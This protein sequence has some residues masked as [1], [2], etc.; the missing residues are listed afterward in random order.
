MICPQCGKSLSSRATICPS[1][2]VAITAADNETAATGSAVSYQPPSPDEQTGPPTTPYA[3]SRY[4]RPPITS[5]EPPATATINPTMTIPVLT[6]SEPPLDETP[7]DDETVWASVPPLMTSAEPEDVPFAMTPAANEPDEPVAPTEPV[8]D[9]LLGDES[10][11]AERPAIA[12]PKPPLPDYDTPDIERPAIHVIKP[13]LPDYDTPDI[14]R[15]AV[16]QALVSAPTDEQLTPIGASDDDE[17]EAE[18]VTMTN[19]AHSAA[20]VPN[21]LSSYLDAYMAQ[22]AA[23]V[24]ATAAAGNAA[25]P[26]A[27]NNNS[28]DTPGGETIERLFGVQPPPRGRTAKNAIQRLW[29]RNMPPEWAVAPWASIP[30]GALAALV[31][32]LLVTAIGLIFWSRA[33]GYLLGLGNALGANESLGQ[34][35]LSPNLLQLFLL[36]HGVPMSLTLGAP[37]VTGSFS[38]LESLPLTGL[39]LIPACALILAGYVAAASDF[40]HRLRFSVLRGALVG[41]VYGVLLLLVAVFGSGTVKLAPNTIIELHPSLGLAFL[42]GLL[43]GALLGALGGLLTI[44]RHHLFT[45]SRHPDLLA[46]ASWGALIALGSGLLLATVALAA[47]MAAHVVGAT[48]PAGPSGN[49]LLNLLGGVVIAISLLIVVAPVGA[50]WLFAL[51]TGATLDSWFSSAGVSPGSGRATFG[52]LVAQHHPASGAWWLLLLVPL[53]SYVIGGRAAAHI[54]RADSLR[55]GA[56]AGWLMGV[57]LSIMLLVLTLLSRVLIAS[58]ATIFGRQVITNLGIAPSA[59]AVFVL[60]LLVGGVV[61]ALAG[62]SALLAPDPG[63]ILAS[64]A[65]PLL[66]RIDPALALAARPGTCSMRPVVASPRTTMRVLF[67]AA[68]LLAVLLLA[69]FLVMVLIGWIAS[70]VAPISAVRGFDSFFAGIAVGVP[71]LLLASAAILA[72]T[73][74]LPPLLTAQHTPAPI[75]PRYPTAQ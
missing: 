12:A 75:I 11:D 34:A 66:P 67:Y 29:L 49:G 55:D 51:G 33:I 40:S 14:E 31:I 15:P 56:L 45:T 16:H 71:L 46:G 60:T 69:L 23:Y 22:P 68:I 30:I 48:P 63:P 38:A 35:V 25:P 8:G 43:W 54:A 50:L 24:N 6:T 9:E 21:T 70:H 18:S 65:T 39:S 20:Q 1:C 72:V 13:P 19:G 7:A 41:P 52:L 28:G 17:T 64:L 26:P 58:D 2:G 53:A 44:R 37:G 61:G 27:T 32:G 36:E 62:I 59:G 57:A 42:A 4:G 74:A 3:H 10:P 73:R 5:P 47:G